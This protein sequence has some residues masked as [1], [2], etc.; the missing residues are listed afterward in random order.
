ML[1]W[2]H[3]RFA[4]F[5]LHWSRVVRSIFLHIVVMKVLHLTLTLP[6][7]YP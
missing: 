6:W 4:W 5:G 2:L 3:S 7:P 1:Q